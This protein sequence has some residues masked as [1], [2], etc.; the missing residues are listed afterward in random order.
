MEPDAAAQAAS[1]A[2]LLVPAEPSTAQLEPQVPGYQIVRRLGSGGMGVVW[3][4]IELRFDRK[5]ALKVHKE[6]MDL[7]AGADL[8]REAHV[9][10]R[11]GDPGIVRVHDVGFTLDGQPYYTMDLVDG[12]DLAALL[13]DGALP[14]ARAVAI[15]MDV[16]TAAGAAH[17][18]GVIHR[19]LKPRNVI[20]DASGRAR[21]VDFGVAY[22]TH[23]GPD[24][25]A[26]TLTGSPSYMSPEQVLGNAITP[27]ADVHAVGLLL[28][29]MLTGRR[30]FEAPTTQDLLAA[31][32]FEEPPLLRS[33]MPSAH[34]DLEHVI[35]RCL[36][37]KPEERYRNGK[38]LAEALRALA[39]GRP[40]EDPSA[41]SRRY[42]PRVASSNPPDKPQRD[43]A[44]KTFRWSWTLKSSPAK[45]WPWVAHTDRFNKSIGLSPVEFAD[46]VTE[47]EG[48]VRTG[49]MR[50]LGIQVR[51]RE[52]PFEWVKEREHS[53]FRWYRQGPL[54]A[55]W[56]RV[57]MTPTPDGGTELVHEV[58]I[59]PRGLLG[60]VA[61]FV[62]I[63]QK[64]GRSMD[65]SYKRLDQVLSGGIDV[66]P[67]EDP[68]VPSATERSAVSQGIEHLRKECGFGGPLLDR[69]ARL[70][71]EGP[72][73]VI[74]VMR[75]YELA[76]LWAADRGE[77]LDLFLHARGVGLVEAAWDV[78]CP[79]CRVPHES[80]P[81]LAEVKRR[82]TCTACATTF[83]RDL[84]ES[85]ELGFRPAAGVRKTKRST[86]CVGAP[87]L[88][89]HVLL[90]QVLDPMEE[91]IIHIEIPRGS[92]MATG[93]RGNTGTE[94]FA[95]ALGFEPTLEISFAE[96]RVE[97]RPP[98][99]R[100]GAV[101]V[102]LR[103]DT[104]K[105][106]TVR[107]EIP[108]HRD[109]SVNAAT[110]L[111]HP[112]FRE[113]FA[114]EKPAEGEALAASRM[115]FLFVDFASRHH[116][117]E[118]LGDD[119]MLALLSSL[120]QVVTDVVRQEQGTVLFAALGTDAFAA[121]FPSALLATRAAVSIH[122]RCRSSELAALP[123]TAVHEG[124]C[125]VLSR[126]NDV[127][128]FGQTIHRGVGLLGDA[129]ERG[130]SLSSS[131][132]ADHTVMSFLL[133]R[134]CA[135]AV[136]ESSDRAYAGRR[137]TLITFLDPPVAADTDPAGT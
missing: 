41:L 103:N 6:K 126:A 44:T 106:Q 93:S 129:P 127:E 59:L 29:L 25:Y 83:E 43:Q 63:N 75:P 47:A 45:L 89:P 49:H 7:A 66:D 94:I 27:A 55:L 71:L 95:S 1:R 131:V 62:E 91:R 67:F 69:F 19:D 134:G 112:T 58:A 114:R 9:A 116:L 104:E 88:R 80:V 31:I 113:F 119:K 42:A 137:V 76:D 24:S 64:A 107:I 124:P 65:R 50:A 37:K 11:I 105:E 135:Q 136:V 61:A 110:A 117:Y 46:A 40:V 14:P 36:A 85:V 81:S 99:I 10:A 102:V 123:R 56:N 132:A 68:Y 125:I 57:T 8:W 84:A 120:E 18:N 2:S 23:A 121:A 15:A 21:V 5:V 30:A 73:Q 96:G 82:G 118:K 33:V 79:T 12:T 97:A 111:V 101:R 38:A 98:M 51:W 16:A 133:Q 20:I 52:Y 32:A 87:A 90:Q 78:V 34:A 35:S 115:A 100:A 108:G 13:L 17:E 128:Y 109:D 54:A 39:E 28:F 60:E 53:V 4:A 70:L 26:G 72:A 130:L 86:Y 3:E 122:D 48:P 92:Y 77:V 22:N 74:S